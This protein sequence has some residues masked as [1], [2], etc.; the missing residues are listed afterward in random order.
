M[1]WPEIFMADADERNAET[2][3]AVKRTEVSLP[4]L[5]CVKYERFGI[6]WGGIVKAY[7]DD[8]PTDNL[9]RKFVGEIYRDGKLMATLSVN[10]GKVKTMNEVLKRVKEAFADHKLIVKRNYPQERWINYG[11]QDKR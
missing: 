10:G 9:A 2:R 4:D 7:I 3:K 11:V 1:S 6:V 5:Y 8:D